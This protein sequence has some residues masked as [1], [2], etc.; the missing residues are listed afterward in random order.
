M[1]KLFV[2]NRTLQITE[3][4]KYLLE[5]LLPK[6]QIHHE[7]QYVCNRRNGL[8]L[9]LVPWQLAHAH[10]YI[11]NGWEVY[12]HHIRI[13]TYMSMFLFLYHVFTLVSTVI[14]LYHYWRVIVFSS[15]W[16]A[17]T[18]SAPT[19]TLPIVW[20]GGNKNLRRKMKIKTHITNNRIWGFFLSLALFFS[21]S[22]PV[23]CIRFIYLSLS[24]ALS[25]TEPDKWTSDGVYYW[26]NN[27]WC[28]WFF[29]L[30]G[31]STQ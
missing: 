4:K 6:K 18:M 21:C 10:S 26:C 22:L 19:T 17:T 9:S 30:A 2:D 12:L 28:D 1:D 8:L 29:F 20:R 23:A 14:L 11:D 3:L 31:W 24:L 27:N 16:M 5:Q 7:R 13:T 15:V 25:L